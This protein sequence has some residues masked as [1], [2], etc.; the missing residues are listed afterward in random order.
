M[1]VESVPSEGST[2]TSRYLL[3]KAKQGSELMYRNNP[4][5]IV[6]DNDEDYYATARVLA[7]F[8][9]FKDFGAAGDGLG[10]AASSRSREDSFERASASAK[11]YMR[12]PR[13]SQTRFPL[14]S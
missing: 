2:S 7:K 8:G 3:L 10:G 11:V 13:P 4:I 12:V 6:E 1:W 5:L 9:S 14:I